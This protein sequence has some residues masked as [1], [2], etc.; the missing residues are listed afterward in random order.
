[1]QYLV[2]FKKQKA[3]KVNAYSIL[4]PNDMAVLPKNSIYAI[5]EL[6]NR[7]Y[8]SEELETIRNKNT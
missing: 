3:E 2:I 5:V 8:S 4:S 6:A 1:M 7:N